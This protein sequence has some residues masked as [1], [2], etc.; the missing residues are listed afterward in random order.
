MNHIVNPTAG[1]QPPEDVAEG[2]EALRRELSRRMTDSAPALDGEA[3][4][5][6]LRRDHAERFANE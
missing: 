1:R 6:A 4:F 3:I 5:A 2:R